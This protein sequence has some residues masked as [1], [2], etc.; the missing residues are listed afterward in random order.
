MFIIRKIV[1]L[2]YHDLSNYTKYKKRKTAYLFSVL[3]MCLDWLNEWI[4]MQ[5]RDIN[6]LNKQEV[7]FT[8]VSFLLF[9]VSMLK[10]I[11]FKPKSQLLCLTF[12]FIR[13]FYP[14][15]T[16]QCIQVIHFVCQYMCSETTCECTCEYETTKQNNESSA[17]GFTLLALLKLHT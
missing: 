16:L 15:P 1:P 10:S 5:T 3:L 4:L 12:T 7:L 11:S 6:C 2:F 17:R 8:L 9:E 13:R 14:K